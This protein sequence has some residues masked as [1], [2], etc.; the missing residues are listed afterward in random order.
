MEKTNDQISQISIHPLLAERDQ[1]A[2]FEC[3]GSFQS[4]RSSRSGTIYGVFYNPTLIFQSTRSSR[5]GTAVTWDMYCSS[6]FQS[7]RSSRSGTE[8]F[9]LPEHELPISIHPLL[10]ERDL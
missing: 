1:V 10:A 9:R 6:K 4:T 8:I 3:L 5:S 2:A 7:T